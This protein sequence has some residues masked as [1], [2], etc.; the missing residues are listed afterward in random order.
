[1]AVI[2]YYLTYAAT[3][4]AVIIGDRKNRI[5]EVGPGHFGLG[6]WLVPVSVVALI[7][8]TIVI[9]AYLWP[10]AN[11]YIFGYFG[12]AM[13]IGALL[14]IYAWSGLKSG[15]ASVPSMEVAPPG[16]AHEG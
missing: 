8:C 11:H 16:A 6:R 2:A 14:T 4:I 1:M 15:R 7:W 13:V 10:A 12:G 9:V 3:M 5:P